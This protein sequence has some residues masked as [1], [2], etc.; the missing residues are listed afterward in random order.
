MTDTTEAPTRFATILMVLG[1]AMMLGGL[2]LLSLGDSAYFLVVGL[3]IAASGY[4]MR[5]GQLLGAIVYGVTLAVVVLWSLAETRGHSG[6]LLP[7]IAMPMV[8]GIYI[9]VSVRPRLR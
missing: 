1:I 7:R 9:F 4:L 6:Q 3:G 8:L 5:Q 2:R